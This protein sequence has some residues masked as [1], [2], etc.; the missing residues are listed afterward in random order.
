MIWGR[1]QGK[2]QEL[3]CRGNNDA[4][5]LVVVAAVAF[6]VAVAVVVALAAVVAVVVY[7]FD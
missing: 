1:R 7:M 4:T 6:V 2:F 5:M 3:C